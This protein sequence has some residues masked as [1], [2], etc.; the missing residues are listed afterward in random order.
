MT[1]EWFIM[2]REQILH[3][4]LAL[5]PEDRAYVADQLEQSLDLAGLA[6]PEL[7]TAWS[8]EIDRRIA[9][10]ERGEIKASDAGASISRMRRFLADHR[11]AS[12]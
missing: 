1:I 7:V 5:G 3:E 10:Y 9:A 12:A 4:A 2:T 8:A 11:R 6:S